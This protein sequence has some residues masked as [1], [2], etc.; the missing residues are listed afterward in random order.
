MICRH[1]VLNPD[2]A[3]AV[4][5]HASA[6][7]VVDGVGLDDGVLVGD[8]ECHVVV[9][10]VR[11]QHEHLTHVEQLRPLDVVRLEAFDGLVEVL[12]LD[13]SQNIC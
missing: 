7:G 1:V 12:G 9:D 5:G 3:C 8:V 4:D 11:A 2:P 13:M 10:G 6:E